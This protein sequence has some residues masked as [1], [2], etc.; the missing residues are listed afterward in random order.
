MAVNDLLSAHYMPSRLWQ[1]RRRQRTGATAIN[2]SHWAPTQVQQRNAMVSTFM[3][4]ALPFLYP[5]SLVCF[6]TRAKLPDRLSELRLVQ[7]QKLILN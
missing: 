3:T 7:G 5:S 4:A 1:A 2:T 6:A